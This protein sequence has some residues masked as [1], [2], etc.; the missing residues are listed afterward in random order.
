MLTRT[1]EPEVVHGTTAGPSGRLVNS[2]LE[3]RWPLV[4]FQ[5]SKGFLRLLETSENNSHSATYD[6]SEFL[7]C[8]LDAHEE[9]CQRCC[10]IGLSKLI[11]EFLKYTISISISIIYL[12]SGTRGVVA[13]SPEPEAHDKSDWLKI[14]IT[15]SKIL[16]SKSLIIALNYLQMYI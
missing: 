15:K 4:G 10:G 5:T 12:S 14:H 8:P 3:L 6:N 2:Q 7:F 16:K 1:P 9:L 11:M 13:Q